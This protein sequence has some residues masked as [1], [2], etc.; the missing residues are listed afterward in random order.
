MSEIFTRQADNMVPIF[1]V[2]GKQFKKKKK[3][4]QPKHIVRLE[5]GGKSH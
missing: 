5:K 4:Q 3:Q 2:V 1:T